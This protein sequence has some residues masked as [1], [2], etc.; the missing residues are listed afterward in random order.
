MA[1]DLSDILESPEPTLLAT[2]FSVTEGPLWHPGG[3]LTFV[4]IRKNQLFRWDLGGKVTVARDNTGQGNGC[5][6]DRQGRL[7]MC[8][9]AD[10]RRITRM[11]AD[12][13]I[14]TIA[15][16]WLGKRLNKPNDVICRS[17]G[18]IFFTDPELRV[19]PELRHERFPAPL[20]LL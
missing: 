6:L 5:T 11:E 13:S 2:G 3:Y 20:P 16:R 12:G 8:E 17:D 14:F 15:D 4:D 19:P 7:N 18:S 1:A 10:H 9:G